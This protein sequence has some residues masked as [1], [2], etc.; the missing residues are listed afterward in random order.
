[1]TGATSGIG[2]ETALGLGR[3]GGTVILV[4]RNADKGHRFASRVA[5][6]IGTGKAH[7]VVADLSSR[8]EIRS[9]A[10]EILRLVPW[11]DVL[12][13]NAGAYFG[14]R[15]TSTDGIEMNLALNH[16]APFGLT[17]RLMGALTRSPAARVVN[18]A[19]DAH[20][21]ATL[22]LDDVQSTR[23]YDRLEAYARSKLANVLFTNGL[24]R[25]LQGTRVTA[26]AVH[27]GV[28][29]T[30]LGG[31]NGWMKTRVRNL[32]RRS[33]LSPA[34][35]ARTSLYVATAPELNGVSGRYFSACKEKRASDAS[36]DVEAA[37]RLWELSE[38]LSGVRWRD[39][40]T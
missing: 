13:N 12:V 27:P 1:M 26:N 36:Y 4:A 31:N 20:R 34:E 37:A 6:S 11:V 8:A 28:V 14:R 35:G 10:E 2:A 24:A 5:R 38:E 19:S 17:L 7:L 15:E 21:T 9:A 23:R 25:R 32:L 30:N 16:L 3:L 22:D 18:V 40:V 29:A 33:M 39:V